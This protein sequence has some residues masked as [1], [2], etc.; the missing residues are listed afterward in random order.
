[1][2]FLKFSYQ[3]CK[4]SCSDNSGVKCTGSC[5]LVFHV[6]R[7]K[8][9]LESMKTSSTK[10][11]KCKDC[12][13]SSIQISGE[14]GSASS[15]VLTKQFLLHVMKA[16]KKDVLTEINTDMSTSVQFVSNKI[17]SSNKLY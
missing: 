4:H 3:F 5:G 13:T 15:T 7:I 2:Y 8:G 17:D 14:S 16:F 6:Y 1:M 12:K 11:F 9:E 10:D